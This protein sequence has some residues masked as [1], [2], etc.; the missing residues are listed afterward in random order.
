MAFLASHAILRVVQ[1]EPSTGTAVS[2]LLI[3]HAE[4]AVGIP[5][6]PDRWRALTRRGKTQAATLAD[7]L[8]PAPELILHSPAR[9]AR[10]TAEIIN[11]HLPSPARLTCAQELYPGDIDSMQRLLA[12]H[13][14]STRVAAIVAHNP[15]ISLFLAHLC[16]AEA[17]ELPPSGAA[18]L[19]CQDWNVRRVSLVRLLLP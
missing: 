18:I 13:A 12:Q 6:Q 7:Q 14:T 8:Q 3:R 9:R 10:Q 4:A 5:G 16:P 19:Q 2:V 15:A 17:V 1:H 11:A